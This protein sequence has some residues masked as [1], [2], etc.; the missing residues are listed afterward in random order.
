MIGA[1][2]ETLIAGEIAHRLGAVHDFSFEA[3][4]G[5]LASYGSV[6]PSRDLSRALYWVPSSLPCAGRIIGAHR[7]GEVLFHQGIHPGDRVHVRAERNRLRLRFR[8][9]VGS[10]GG[11]RGQLDPW[12]I[13]TAKNGKD[14]YNQRQYKKGTP[15]LGH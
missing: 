1:G 8:I 3:E 7:F 2:L 10:H 5:A 14:K 4:A 15:R 9:G 6:R 13:K 12:T 11:S